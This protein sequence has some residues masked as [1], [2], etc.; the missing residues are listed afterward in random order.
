MTITELGRG[1]PVSPHRHSL[2]IEGISYFSLANQLLFSTDGVSPFIAI[3]DIHV[4]LNLM[5]T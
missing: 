2:W 3:R 1:L 5:K 4:P